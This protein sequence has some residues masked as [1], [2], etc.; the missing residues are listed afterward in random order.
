MNLFFIVV[1]LL[2][3][4]LATAV[5]FTQ[6]FEWPAGL[7]YEWPS[8]EKRIQAL[9]S[10]AFK[11]QNI[12]P[13]F[14]A[15]YGTRIF[16]SLEKYVVI[17]VTLG[18]LPTS[19]ET[20]AP[21]KL[22]PFPSW[23]MHKDEHGDCNKIEE[24]KGLEVDS[25]GR[26]WVIDSGSENCNAKLWIFNLANNDKTELIHRFSFAKYLADL[27]LDETPNGY[28]AYM[29]RWRHQHIVVFSLGKNQSWTVDTPGVEAYSIARSP[30]K[31]P[32]QIYLSNSRNFDTSEFFSISATALRSNGT[33][34]AYPKLIGQWTE[35][36]PYRMLMDNHGTMYAAFYRKNYIASWNPY[37]S[38]QEQR[39]LEVIEKL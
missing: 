9:G 23:D 31:E 20:S 16:L 15:V 32:R 26:L 30:K 36:L 19:S 3:L 22:T 18:S 33:Q 25:F 37:Q 2:C 13:I 10:G 7:N 21:P 24:A 11:P 38:M 35:I 4:S 17:P 8:E 14:M 27:V 29:A 34:T 6:V 1:I 12:E 28:F 39:F 5:N